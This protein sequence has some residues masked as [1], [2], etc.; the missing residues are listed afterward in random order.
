LNTNS[1][2]YHNDLW[3]YNPST[4]Q[5]KGVSGS[6]GSGQDGNYGTQ[7][8]PSVSNRPGARYGGVS[9][10]G[11]NE[12]LYL[13][14]GVGYPWNNN[15]GDLNDLW[16]FD[17][18]SSCVYCNNINLPSAAWQSSIRLSVKNS[19]ST[20]SMHLQIIHH[21]GFGNFRRHSRFIYRSKS[22]NICYSNPGT[23][24]VTLITTNSYGSDTLTLT[25]FIT[26]YP[27]PAFPS[28]TQNGYTLTSSAAATYQW[29]FN[30]VDIPGATNQSYNVTQ[31]GYYSVFITDSNG[32]TSSA[33]AYVVIVGIDDL[34]ADEVI[35]VYPNPSKGKFTIELLHPLSLQHD[36]SFRIVNTLG[37][38]VFYSEKEGSDVAD[39][40]MEIDLHQPAGVY[41]LQLITENDLMNYKV[42]IEK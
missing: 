27:T 21:H 34:V 14:G 6:T 32:C 9:W 19:A 28:I 37:Q 15:V 12:S 4:N 36:R 29:Q 2:A 35:S 20:F 13:F 16:R 38:T 3:C 11:P 39:R 25:N 33:T 41:F 30:S 7:G 1:G 10:V 17:P 42:I 5:W 40:K 18:D 22:N 31:T 23:Y 8:V 24:D 26:V